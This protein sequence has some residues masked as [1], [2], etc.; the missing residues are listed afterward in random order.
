MKRIK[1]FQ[2]TLA[3][4]LGTQITA[5]TQQKSKTPFT[6]VDVELISSYEKDSRSNFLKDIFQIS[7]GQMLN[8]DDPNSFSFNLV[9]Y[10]KNNSFNTEYDLHIE[11]RQVVFDIC[12]HYLNEDKLVF[13]DR[14]EEA[15]FFLYYF[16]S[17][18]ASNW[19]QSYTLGNEY[20]LK[21]KIKRELESISLDDLVPRLRKAVVVSMDMYPKH[22]LSEALTLI[23]LTQHYADLRIKLSGKI[24]NAANQ[25]LFTS[26]NAGEEFK[27]IFLNQVEDKI[28]YENAEL[29]LA[30]RELGEFKYSMDEKWLNH[31]LDIFKNSF[32]KG[33]EDLSDI[34]IE[35]KEPLLKEKNSTE[36]AFPV[37]IRNLGLSREQLEKTIGAQDLS[38]LL[39]FKSNKKMQ[40]QYDLIFLELYYAGFY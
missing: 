21:A 8:M 38:F 7:F 6:V 36:G 23:I 17:T 29:W 35:N 24:L 9:W 37:I 14:V 10:C 19:L 18:M 3:F 25:S 2:L 15:R 27:A 40:E 39:D 22:T 5:H 1:F 31:K 13:E 20:Y 16:A 32:A 28:L 4:L 26:T 12:R 34:G 33:F 11:E 30:N